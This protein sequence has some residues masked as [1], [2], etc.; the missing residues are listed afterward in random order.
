[1]SLSPYELQRLKNIEENNKALAAFGLDSATL[2]WLTKPADT[3]AKDSKSHRKRK[4]DEVPD[5]TDRKLRSRTNT[6][7][8]TFNVDLDQCDKIIKRK[9]RDSRNS[10][11]PDRFENYQATQQPKPRGKKKEDKHDEEDKEDFHLNLRLQDA[12]GSTS[13]DS[14]ELSPAQ[15]T[16]LWKMGY[17][18]SDL[19]A[20]KYPDK[21]VEQM[22]FVETNNARNYQVPAFELARYEEMR[23][24]KADKPKVKCPKC[25]AAFCCNKT[26]RG[27]T[28]RKHDC[29]PNQYF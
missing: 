5:P 15:L 14:V 24:Y 20:A 22:K 12:T 3:K 28:I 9:K 18:S 4:L 29:V 11:Q 1:M 10:K 13:S 16:N 6:P 8:Y 27:Y 17:T 23:R 2:P 21:L 19:K 7:V 26:D 25:H